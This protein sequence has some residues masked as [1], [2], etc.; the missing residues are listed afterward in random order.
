MKL[1]A[2]LALIFATL[3]LVA[4]A[5]S[6]ITLRQNDRVVIVGGGP[7]GVHYA[8]LLVKK[9][10]KKV[11]L[12]EALDRVGGKSRTEIDRDGI[13][14]ELGTCFLNGIYGPIFDLLNEY[15]PTNEKFVWALNAPNYVKVLGESIGVADSDPVS[16]LDY[17]RYLI[18]S[19]A[20]N[21]PPELQRNANVTE[22]QDLVRFQIGRY[23]ALHYAIFGKYSY[24][25]PPPPKDWS[26]IDMTAMEFLKRN[27]LTAL[28]G[29]LRFS[30]QQQG[31]GVLETIPA[32]YMLWWMHPDQF[33]KKTNVYSL[34]K[35]FQSL[36]TAVHAAHKN[37]YK[38]IFL[39]R[40][41]SVSRGNKWNKPRVTYQTRWGDLDTI[42]A[43][44]VVMAVDLSLYA[45]LVEDLSAEEKQ[46]F[47][48]GDY[49]ASAFLS[50]LYESDASP[51]ETASVGWF[52]RMQENGR[53]SAVR[54]SKLSYLF[55]NSTDWGDLAKGRQTNLAYQY[56]SHPLDKVNSTASKAQLDAD[57]K[58]AGIKNVEVTTQL[59]TNYFPRFTPAGLKKGLLWKIWD[60]QGQRKT[61]WIG[62][63]V[64]FESVLD[65]VVY[66]NNLIQ[67]VNVTVPKKQ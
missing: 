26:L 10:L 15:D 48:G 35:G 53:V 27:N 9:G 37:Q 63:S 61:T 64:S 7:A 46:L 1:L 34:R 45:G 6:P 39:A 32:F 17:P 54:N 30:Q 51:I 29:T 50:T 16:N 3:S 38:T 12:L 8:S 44:H 49:T 47:Q 14:H 52:G 21:A 65:V 42:E 20:L 5:P 56:Y 66:N 41:T 43:D 36:W 62:S 18:R 67:Y 19:I 55:T 40:A 23:I 31:Y 25:L 59:H 57:L 24:G 11:V 60:I 33:L 13:P 4:S 58:L 22:L 28:E 2:S